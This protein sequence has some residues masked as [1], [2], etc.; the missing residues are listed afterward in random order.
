L[1]ASI[2]S[3]IA[4]DAERP[5]S[6]Q[7]GAVAVPER[8]LLMIRSVILARV[9]EQYGF[10]A[11]TKLQVPEIVWRG[12]E[13]C[14]KGYLRA[15]F[16]TDGTVNIAGNNDTSCSV[17]LASSQPSLLKDVQILLANFGI[18]ARVSKRREAGSR[19]LP[20]GKGGTKEYA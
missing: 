2:N 10:T 4:G 3:M 18:F 5:R 6:Y 1:V 20:D 9:L 8:N 13:E 12:N 19:F 17:R 11:K 7:V 16:Q 14:V 15:L